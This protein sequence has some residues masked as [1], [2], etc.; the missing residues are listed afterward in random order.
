MF[1]P[2]TAA[3]SRD[4]SVSHQMSMTTREHFQMFSIKAIVL[5]Q[6]D[7]FQE[8]KRMDDRTMRF[9]M[10]LFILWSLFYVTCLDPR[11]P[12]FYPGRARKSCKDIFNQYIFIHLKPDLSL[13]S[14]D[15][16]QR[17]N[18]SR[19][20]SPKARVYKQFGSKTR[21]KSL[22]LYCQLFDSVLFQCIPIICYEM[23]DDLFISLSREFKS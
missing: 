5:K 6:I 9:W 23:F 19:R 7:Y 1:I 10:R 18:L 3:Y 4:I 12:H 11:N 15:L 22:S 2:F 17:E 21:T 8:G 20:R 13:N 16:S 14:W